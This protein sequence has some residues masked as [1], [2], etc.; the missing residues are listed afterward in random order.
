M[1]LMDYVDQL[2]EDLKTSPEAV[3]YM[4]L[5]NYPV[6]DEI[7]EQNTLNAKADLLSL[8]RYVKDRIEGEID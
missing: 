7:I 6:R 2:A 1:N 8:L 3:Q 5:I 4:A